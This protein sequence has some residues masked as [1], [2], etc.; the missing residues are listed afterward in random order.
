MKMGQRFQILISLPAKQ[1]GEGNPNN[2]PR[3]TIT[4]HNQWLYGVSAIDYAEKLLNAL[5]LVRNRPYLDW[6]NAV[7]DAIKHVSYLNVISPKRTYRYFDAEDDEALVRG[8][9]KL[10]NY[11]KELDNNNGFLFVFID[12]HNE[13][14]YRLFNG[15]EDDDAIKQRTPLEY[16]SLFYDEQERKDF[17]LSCVTKL[18]SYPVITDR[19]FKLI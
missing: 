1:Y 5:T 15:L 17:D 11:L 6:D 12:D 8:N 16:L 19:H 9:K 18:E 14:S 4:Y 7:D 10:M 2:K 13:P 3:R